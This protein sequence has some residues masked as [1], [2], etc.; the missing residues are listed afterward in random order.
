[1][2]EKDKSAY[3]AELIAQGYDPAKAAEMA[4]AAMLSTEYDWAKQGMQG[5]GKDYGIRTGGRYG[6]YVANPGASFLGGMR[7]G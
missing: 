4:E 7:A 5:L 2:A 1:M 3:E 6:T